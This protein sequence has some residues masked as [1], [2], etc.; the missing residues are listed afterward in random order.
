MEARADET[1][2][3]IEVKMD[4]HVTDPESELAVQIPDELKPQVE[5][6]PH[7]RI[8][9][10]LRADDP[11]AVQALPPTDNPMLVHVSDEEQQAIREARQAARERDAERDETVAAALAAPI[12]V[13]LPPAD[14]PA[15]AANE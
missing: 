3:L 13:G 12:D 11:L 10:V 7:G 8:E 15:P 14:A 4:A 1:G 9:K 5:E 2:R 6:R